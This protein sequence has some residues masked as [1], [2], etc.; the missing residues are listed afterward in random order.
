M[1]DT[2]PPSASALPDTVK[3]L[4]VPD[5]VR[6]R[7]ADFATNAAKAALGNAYARPEAANFIDR[8][9][10]ALRIIHALRCQ[11]AGE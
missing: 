7:R 8:S 9:P 4:P 1:Y 11:G 10:G 5:T 3:D 2:R 6:R